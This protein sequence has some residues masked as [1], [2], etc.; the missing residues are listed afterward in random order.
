MHC[1]YCFVEEG[2]P[3]TDACNRAMG[4]PVAEAP[5]PPVKQTV[6]RIWLR[7]GAG[8]LDLPVMPEFNMGLFAQ[9]VRGA[10]GFINE[11]NWIPLECILGTAMH[12]VDAPP[13]GKIVPFKP[14]LAV[15]NGGG[16]A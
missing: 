1:S 4:Q 10:G 7:W 5:K 11:N 15:D 14:S 3:H 13:T 6:I 16:A 2:Q 9:Q 8:F 12:V